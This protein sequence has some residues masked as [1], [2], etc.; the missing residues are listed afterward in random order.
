M[1][2]RPTR[3]YLFYD[4]HGALVWQIPWT[5]SEPPYLVETRAPGTSEG[6]DGF[7]WLDGADGETVH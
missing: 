2:G 3:L 4:R 7:D 5:D 1:K 6:G